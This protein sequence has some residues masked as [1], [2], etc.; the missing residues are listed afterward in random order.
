MGRC[1]DFETMVQSTECSFFISVSDYYCDVVVN[2]DSHHY[3][4]M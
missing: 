2:E 3:L 1:T 4:V